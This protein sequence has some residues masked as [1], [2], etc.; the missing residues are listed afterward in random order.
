MYPVKK[1]IDR[2]KKT[3]IKLFIFIVIYSLMIVLAN[4]FL[5]NLTN[6]GRIVSGVIAVISILLTELIMNKLTPKHKPK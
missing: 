4:T 5:S 1:E 6:T 2:L 3:L